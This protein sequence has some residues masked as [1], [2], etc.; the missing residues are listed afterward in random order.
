[1]KIRRTEKIAVKKLSRMQYRKEK[2][3]R[4]LKR[5][6]KDKVRK[7]NLFN[8]ERRIIMGTEAMFSPNCKEF[9]QMLTPI[10]NFKKPQFKNDNR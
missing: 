3:G 9:P 5:N 6:R 10:H 1:M 7:L 8:Q 4:K 2:Y